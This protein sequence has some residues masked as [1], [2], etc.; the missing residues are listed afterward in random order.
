MESSISAPPALNLATLQAVPD[1]VVPPPP[2]AHEAELVATIDVVPFHAVEQTA[3]I[4]TLT[5]PKVPPPTRPLPTQRPVI[6]PT[7][8]RPAQAD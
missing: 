5:S 8:L 2:P 3:S 4:H 6:S 1:I 7:Q